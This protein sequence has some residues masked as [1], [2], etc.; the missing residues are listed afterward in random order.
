MRRTL[1]KHGL[2]TATFDTSGPVG[3]Q[4]VD[5]A[6]RINGCDRFIAICIQ[7]VVLVLPR[8]DVDCD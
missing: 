6:Q 3:V 2:A 4:V 7:R 5:A 1:I 8:I